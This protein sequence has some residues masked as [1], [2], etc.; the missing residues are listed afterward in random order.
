MNSV[1]QQFY[2][3]FENRFRGDYK[4]ILKRLELYE[5]LIKIYNKR[6]LK[7]FFLDIG[8]GRGEWLELLQ[9]NNSN[10]LGIDVFDNLEIKLSSKNFI[11]EDFKKYLSTLK[12]NSIDFV[13][14][15]HLIEHL[16]F[17]E[18]KK[19]VKEVSRVLKPNGLFLLET[20]NQKNISVS[21]INFS[22]DPTHIKPVNHELFLFMMEEYGF[23]KTASFGVNHNIFYKNKLNMHDIIYSVSP[24]FTFMGFKKISDVTLI[25]DINSYLKNKIN[26]NIDFFINEYEKNLERKLVDLEKKLDSQIQF[27]HKRINDN[28]VSIDYIFRLIRPVIL[29]S[30]IKKLI[31][32]LFKQK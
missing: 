1:D 26:Y 17:N 25:K 20:P 27:T 22:V 11:K 2:K 12:N 21:L 19:L 8:C 13:S 32:N 14:S 4:Q 6:F 10:F 16:D 24:D 31:K 9:R 5:P 28:Q 3:K 29:L 30:N 15:F 7:P 23:S 18:Q